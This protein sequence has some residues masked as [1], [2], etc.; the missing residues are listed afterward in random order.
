[1]ID[2]ELVPW[3]Y[4]E[5]AIIRDIERIK[6]DWHGKKFDLELK[7]LEAKVETFNHFAGILKTLGP[8]EQREFLTKLR[9]Q[10]PA[11][12]TPFVKGCEFLSWDDVSKLASEPLVTI[13]A[14]T[15][16]HFV[17]SCLSE[18]EFRHEADGSRKTLEEKLGR[19]IEHF[20]Y[21]FGSRS[22]AG[23]REFRIVG[24]LGFS[25][26]FTTRTGH[27]HSWHRDSLYSLPRIVI[28]CYDTVDDLKWKL[29]GFDSTLRSLG[30]MISA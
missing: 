12:A 11:G 3:W 19:K 21:P 24:A 28:G 10:L 26:A 25:S 9:E 6:F 30:E 14:H 2:G 20:A 17:S 16:H 29:G 5:E 7:D 22:E 13:G 8:G 4:E 1:M 23:E 15:K 18:E 27:L